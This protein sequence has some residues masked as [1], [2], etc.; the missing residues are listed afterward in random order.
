M[1]KKSK[2]KKPVTT[3]KCPQCGTRSERI[4]IESRCT[5]KLTIADNSYDDM[6]A[7]ETLAGYC[8]ECTASIPLRTVK[9]LEVAGMGE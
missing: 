3:Y 9:R 8:I 7:G 5:Q 6:E 2:I 1:S 4:I